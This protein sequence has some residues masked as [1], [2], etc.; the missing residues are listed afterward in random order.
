MT[1]NSNRSL[2][3]CQTDEKKLH[4]LREAL[5]RGEKSGWVA[6]FNAEVVLKKIKEA[7]TKKY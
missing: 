7:N 3:A 4:E 2:E 5:I 6:D 1:Q